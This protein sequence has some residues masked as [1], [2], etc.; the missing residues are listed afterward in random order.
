MEVPIERVEEIS[1]VMYSLLGGVSYPWIPSSRTTQLPIGQEINEWDL[2]M[3]GLL[4]LMHVRS[5]ESAYI[6]VCHSLYRGTGGSWE[7]A[8]LLVGWSPAKHGHST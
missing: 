6:P 1:L 3:Q 2:S 7:Q 5:G 8:D 4:C